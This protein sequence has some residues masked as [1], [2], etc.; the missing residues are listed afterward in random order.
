MGIAFSKQYSGNNNPS[1]VDGKNA[2]RAKERDAYRATIE[3]KNFIRGVFI[4][5]KNKCQDCGLLRKRIKD[6]KGKNNNFTVHHIKPWKTHPKLRFKVS[7]GI[8]LCQ[9]CHMKRHHKKYNEA[10][11]W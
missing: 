10:I 2:E 9:P 6:G 8:V 7:N 1:Y 5:D 11:K 4:R 3:Y